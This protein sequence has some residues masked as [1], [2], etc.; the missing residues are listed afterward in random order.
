MNLAQRLAALALLAAALAFHAPHAR[1]WGGDGHQ[2]VGAIA[3]QLLAGS[4]AA[5]E[6]KRLLGGL[7]LRDAATWAD[8]AK[9]VERDGDYGWR[10]AT[11]GRYRDCR[12]FESDAGERA[13]VDFVRRN[14]DNCRREP[15]D[16]I[17][18]KGYH[19]TDVALQRRAWALG[20]VGTR[21]SDIVGATTAAIR[22]LRSGFAPPPF[23]FESRREALLLLAHYVGD[24]HQPLH[25]GAVYLD[26]AGQ[27]VDPDNDVYDRRRMETTGGNAIRSLRADGREGASLHAL[28]DDVPAALG[29]DRIDARWLAS[30]RRV[31]QSDGP[32]DDW[33][34]QWAT[35][36]LSQAR[37]AYRDI[38][39]SPREGG[40]WDARLPGGYKDM[41]TDIQKTQLT[42]AGAR[43]AQVLRAIWP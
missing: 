1:A 7:S 28:W 42:L 15:G 35:Q 17:C 24:I 8:C 37:R 36:S 21:E 20:R 32:I 2:T 33:P 10:Y 22:M 38:D 27:R 11:E 4:R 5:D 16:E 14:E 30:A 13:M 26:D 18:H 23:R 43:L 25:V 39:F 19:Y 29:P 40:H 9:G 34:A 41:K 12:I 3:D 31:A 6:V